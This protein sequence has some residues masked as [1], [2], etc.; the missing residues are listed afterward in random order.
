MGLLLAV[1]GAGV[2]LMWLFWKPS[3]ALQIEDS[4][5][6]IANGA[7]ALKSRSS[8]WAQ[9][10]LAVSRFERQDMKLHVKQ[11]VARK[12][13]ER[14]EE[15]NV[16][17]AQNTELREHYETIRAQVEDAL[18]SSPSVGTDNVNVA[19]NSRAN[20][21]SDA[22]ALAAEHR[23]PEPT[24]EIEAW[25]REEYARRKAVRDQEL[26]VWF[27]AK[28]DRRNQFAEVMDELSCH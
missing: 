11:D 10:A 9:R 20:S 18:T 23:I 3:R 15:R 8:E 13:V 16:W 24:E 12:R 7:E 5:Q 4:L 2:L 22:N 21:Y 1:V 14:L 28:P 19:T 25:A 17:L 26:E 27:A 6:S